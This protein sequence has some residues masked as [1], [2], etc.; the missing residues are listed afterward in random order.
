[1]D[2]SEIRPG[3]VLP[4]LL[5]TLPTQ[6]YYWPYVTQVANYWHNL[7]SDCNSMQQWLINFWFGLFDRA[8]ISL[9]VHQILIIL[10]EWP[11][12]YEW[13]CKAYCVPIISTRYIPIISTCTF[14]HWPI[15]GSL[16]EFVSNC[17]MPCWFTVTILWNTQSLDNS[18]SFMKMRPAIW[19][20]FRLDTNILF[21]ED[22]ILSTFTK[23]D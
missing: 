12:S 14:A 21:F 19:E 2:S 10:H 7:V 1:M 3:K 5:Y 13:D 9:L 23:N 6:I 17:P 4:S 20:I 11:L 18:R 8:V 22:F 15:I 16:N